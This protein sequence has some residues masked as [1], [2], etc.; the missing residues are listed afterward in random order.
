MPKRAPISLAQRFA[1]KPADDHDQAASSAE[2]SSAPPSAPESTP[3]PRAEP[4]DEATVGVMIRV[5]KSLHKALRRLAFDRE[6]TLQAMLIG[7][8]RRLTESK[9]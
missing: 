8:M 4:A 1:E 3:A 2:A 5:P 6:T 7:E 9:Q